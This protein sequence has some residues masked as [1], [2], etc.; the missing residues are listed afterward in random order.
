M[1]VNVGSKLILGCGPRHVRQP[2]EILLDI[3]EFPGV[4][5]VWDLDRHPW[6]FDD[7]SMTGVVAVHVVEH[8]KTLLLP[9]MDEAWRILRPGG[10]LY[11]ETPLAGANV[12]LEMC[13]P[14]HVRCYR[15]HSFVN[16]FSLE[17]VEKFGYTDRAW[18][19][20]HLQHRKTDDSLVVHAY[21]IKS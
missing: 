19:F 20:F 18:N 6:P 2:G 4:E 11:L 9:F 13:D 15:I 21:P 10:S 8:L 16:Y 3:R 12:D 5:V 7:N 14:T 1:G 17:G